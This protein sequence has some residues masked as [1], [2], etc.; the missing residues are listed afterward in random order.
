MWEDSLPVFSKKMGIFKALRIEHRATS[1]CLDSVCD[2]HG[3]YWKEGQVFT[4]PS[5]EGKAHPELSASGDTNYI[6]CF[7]QAFLSLSPTKASL[8]F[9]TWW[10]EVGGISCNDPRYEKHE[11]F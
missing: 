7:A 6:Q 4:D 10:A 9:W 8:A 1:G 11:L 3:G 5:L 2:E